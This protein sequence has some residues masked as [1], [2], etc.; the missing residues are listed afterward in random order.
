MRHD[1]RAALDVVDRDLADRAVQE[2]L[3]VAPAPEER[4]VARLRLDRVMR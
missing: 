3:Y 1:Q 4:R 2:R